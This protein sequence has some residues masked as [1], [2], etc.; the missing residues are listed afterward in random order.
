ILNEVSISL[1]DELVGPAWRKDRLTSEER[2]VDLEVRAI[3]NRSLD[4][5]V[6]EVNPALDPVHSDPEPPVCVPVVPPVP[7]A[8]GRHP[9]ARAGSLY[10]PA[11]V[12]RARAFGCR[13]ANLA[14]VAGCSL[15]S[16]R[17]QQK[18]E[19]RN[20]PEP[21]HS[22]RAARSNRPHSDHAVFECMPMGPPQHER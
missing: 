19:D 9:A 15:S 2:L 4:R 14:A 1:H 11:P 17:H 8:E 21:C 3:R 6:A 20:Y 13:P 22:P 5:N 16:H 18:P 7:P 12:V 10:S